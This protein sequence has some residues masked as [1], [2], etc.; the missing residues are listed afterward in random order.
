MIAGKPAT[1]TVKKYGKP[2]VISI[3]T[4]KNKI[5]VVIKESIGQPLNRP[6]VK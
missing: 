5:K 6:A 1:T 3:T 2:I 4:A